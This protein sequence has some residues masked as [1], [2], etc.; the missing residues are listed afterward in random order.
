[1]KKQ[2]LLCS[3][4]ALAAVTQFGCGRP[5]TEIGS[6]GPARSATA[7]Q[8]VDALPIF[9]TFINQAIEIDQLGAGLAPED[10]NLFAGMDPADNSPSAQKPS[11][12]TLPFIDWDDLASDLPNH[13]LLDQNAAGGKDPSSFPQANECVGESNVL[14]KM[15]LTYV[16]AANNNAWAYFAVQRS[17]NNGDAAYYWLFTRLAPHL[18]PGEAPCRA[19]DSRLL[20]DISIGDVLLGGHFHPTGTPLVTVY[21]AKQNLA[22]VAAVNAIDFSNTSLWEPHPSGVGAFAVN[23]T[24][25]R[26]GALGSAGVIAASGLDVQQEIFAESA[27]PVHVFTGGSNCGAVFHGSVIT[28]SSGSGGTS[29]DLK[30][31]AGPAVFNFGNATAE[32][33]L[34]PTCTLDVQYE[35][36]GFGFDGQPMANPL[37]VWHF[38]DGTAAT[39]CAG[40]QALS[41][42]ARSA[43]V[44]VSDPTA[45]SCQATAATAPVTVFPPMAV[46]ADLQGS[47]LGTFAY[48]A[49]AT[50]GSGNHSYQWSFGEGVS[51][52]DLTAPT[53]TATVAHGAVT[54]PGNVVATDVGRPDNLICTATGGDGAAVYKPTSATAQLRPTCTLDVQYEVT[55]TSGGAGTPIPNPI[56]EWTFDDGSTAVGCSG[57]RAFPAVQGGTPHGATVK[58]TDPNVIVPDPTAPGCSDTDAASVIVYPPLAVTADLEGTCVGTFTF[59]SQ[60]SGGTGKFTYQWAF[61][62]PGVVTPSSTDGPSGSAAVDSG[63]QTYVGTVVLTDQR[64][65]GLVCSVAG[66]DPTRVFMPIQVNLA[67]AASGPTCPGMLSDRAQYI[68]NPSGGSGAHELIW[69]GAQC[70]GSV[71]TIDPPDDAFCYSQSFSVTAKDTDPVAA[72]LCAAATSE[73]ETYSKLTL[74]DATDN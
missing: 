45:P 34:V 14:S 64:T 58:V 72:S 12:G 11:G 74:V 69:S 59:S 63:N 62:G 61:A 56:C 7:R 4:V 46:T 10:A 67:R 28:R 21:T 6:A 32:A 57:L 36:K 40:V 70:V 68:A 51:A 42:G 30:D 22:G 24:L 9:N 60:A 38:D 55:S 1:M 5:E 39:G 71:C 25:T 15:D 23:T 50:G 35:A 33:K 52:S 54:Y 2:K 65:D 31:L 8:A 49:V 13:L 16:A 18:T 3:A 53:G 47:C 44:T 26:A 41:A 19:T 73:T 27:V 48:S 37:C 29:P 20:Y 43:T 17:D 66:A